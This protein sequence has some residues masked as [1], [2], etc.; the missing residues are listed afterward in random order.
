LIPITKAHTDGDTLV[1]FPGEDVLMTG[2]YFRSVGYPNIDLGNG[3]SLKGIVEAM[4][5][6]IGLCGP[7]LK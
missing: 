5:E 2:D 1:R 4:G 6:T 7:I 3:G